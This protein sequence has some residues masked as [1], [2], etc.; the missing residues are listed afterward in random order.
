MRR[1]Y[2]YVISRKLEMRK[3]DHARRV[4]KKFKCVYEFAVDRALELM[5]VRKK[6]TLPPVSPSL[7]APSSH[8]AGT[9]T[10]TS[11]VTPSV[12][13]LNKINSA[14]KGDAP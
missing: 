3:S 11:S 13:F 14:F 12:I 10:G 2:L 5:P 9:A 4:L 7:V 6:R 1:L 8:G